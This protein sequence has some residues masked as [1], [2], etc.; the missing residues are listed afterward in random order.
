[1]SSSSTPDVLI[2]GGGAIGCAIAWRLAQRGARVRLLERDT[3]AHA[4]S[5]AAAGMLSPR[6]DAGDDPDF[7]ALAY[8]SFELYPHFIE[9]LEA[10]TR[11]RIEYAREGK[12]ELAF[13]EKTMQHLRERHG[14]SATEFMDAELARDL[15]PALS[16]DVV[17]AA[18][19]RDDHRVDNRALAL[20]LWHVAAA[21]GTAFELGSSAVAI[22]R[23]HRG[24]RVLLADG[25][26]ASAD[27]VVL[28]AGAWSG[29][30]AGL[31]HTPPVEPVRGQ[32]LALRMIPPPFI[33]VLQSEHCYLVPRADGRV[34]VGATLEHA[35]FQVQNT[36]GGLRSLLNAAVQIAPLLEHA[37]VVETWAGL[38][39]DT[40]DDLPILG[41]DPEMPGLIHATGHYR[42][43]I[44]LTP[45][46]A[47]LIAAHIAGV[48]TPEL[49]KFSIGR[50]RGRD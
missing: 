4:A 30:I 18:L 37:P 11:Q 24:L 36:A 49:D 34:L 31:P 5:W 27:H 38:R 42:N 25:T 16:S 13:D 40:P 8:R 43:G 47:E 44:L 3:P 50:F 6:V 48:P 17:G 19:V 1:M 45:V 39:P 14:E 7:A 26:A 15:V 29:Q 21:H 20:A 35:G 28:A 22:E 9:E 46:T 33:P 10:S 41:P 23:H 12:L 32:I 2:I